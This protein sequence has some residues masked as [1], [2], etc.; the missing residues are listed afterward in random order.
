MY[1]KEQRG[2]AMD[3]WFEMLGTI[4]MEEFVAELGWPSLSCLARWV[5]ADPRHDPDR[6]SYRSKPMAT[7]LDVVRRIAG[8]EPVARAARAAGIC[9]KSA[10]NL[11]KMYAEGGTAALLP[12]ATIRK[13]AMTAQ[14]KQTQKKTRPAPYER[15]PAVPAELPDDPAALK[16]IIG[17]LQMD[18]AIL[19]EVLDVLKADPGCEPSALTS[20]EKAVVICN[21]DGRFAAKA[22]AARL[23]IP[24]STYY[25]ALA[26]IT[27][28]SA[29]DAIAAQVREIFEADGESARGYRFVKAV[30]DERLGRHVS[31]K[32]VRDSMREQG[33]RVV[34]RAKAGR[35]SSYAGEVD[36]AVPNLLL[37]P[38]GTHDFRAPRPNARWASDITEFRLPGDGP[39]VYLSPVID[40][41]D[42]KPVGWSI[43][44][45][46]DAELAN[47]SLAAACSTLAPGEA[48]LVHTDRGGHYRWDGWKGICEAYGLTRSMSRKGRSPDNA[49]ME[50]FFGRLKNEFFYGRDWSGVG[51]DAFIA[52]LDAWMRRYSTAR[53]RAFRIGGRTV[54]DTID[55]N[56]RRLGLA[57]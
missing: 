54:Y 32:L 15:P 51:A 24:R 17:E 44:T 26:S 2:L 18:N 12:K 55:G 19:R 10:A 11:Y 53:L 36:A 6:A 40:L 27:A 25:H 56:R 34:Y 14:K 38:D 9:D 8:G 35:Y 30:L 1:S 52:L 29:R 5:A 7:K 28:P 33:L 50:G 3:L 47:S 43:S 22:L 16:A 42:G 46:P 57:A 13:A 41:F 45:R 31:E 49:A 23:G 39:K 4:S 20:K 21:L 48:P 37:R